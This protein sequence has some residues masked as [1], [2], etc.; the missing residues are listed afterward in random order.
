M[1]YPVPH[2]YLGII[3]WRCATTCPSSTWYRTISSWTTPF[4]LVLLTWSRFLVL[5]L[6]IAPYCTFIYSIGL[7]SSTSIQLAKVTT[8][9]SSPS[10]HTHCP[11]K[12]PTQFMLGLISRK[13]AWRRLNFWIML[14]QVSPCPTPWIVSH[15]GTAT[16][17]F[18][19]KLD[20]VLKYNYL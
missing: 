5:L 16:T 20:N 2:L 19:L 8:Q 15:F 4:S 14:E 7:I 1:L 10:T 17:K 18:I 11:T 6:L 13:W 12:M 3:S 9:L